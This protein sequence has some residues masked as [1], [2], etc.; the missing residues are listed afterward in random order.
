MLKLKVKYFTHTRAILSILALRLD[1]DDTMENRNQPSRLHIMLSL[2]NQLDS[3]VV[4][5]K[6]ITEG[7]IRS[8]R[9]HRSL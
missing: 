5:V 4:G 6:E 1:M 2:F 9:I 3:E 8:K 7:F